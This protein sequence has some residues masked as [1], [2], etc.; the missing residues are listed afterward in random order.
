MKESR[1]RKQLYRDRM[2]KQLRDSHSK[3]LELEDYPQ[4]DTIPGLEQDLDR[5]IGA[6]TGNDEFAY[7]RSETFCMTDYQRAISALVNQ[8]SVLFSQIP[9]LH[10]STPKDRIWRFITLIFMEHD[11]QVHLRQEGNDIWVFKRDFDEEIEN[12]K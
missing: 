5:L 8:R 6:E 1:E 11:R 2:R 7:D 12:L 3:E 10:P 9:A 4:L